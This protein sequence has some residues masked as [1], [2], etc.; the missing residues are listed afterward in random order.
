[1][2]M[3]FLIP[4]AP[5]QLNL[6]AAAQQHQMQRPGDAASYQHQAATGQLGGF[7]S[8]APAAATAPPTLPLPAGAANPFFN[9]PPLM[10]TGDASSSSLPRAPVAL[11]PQ[12][13][14]AG[15]S[16]LVAGGGAQLPGGG[17]AP[18]TLAIVNGVPVMLDLAKLVELMQMGASLSMV[19]PTADMVNNAAAAAAASAWSSMG[20]QAAATPPPAAKLADTRLA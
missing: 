7:M 3:P 17:V 19:Q 1:M 18:S 6:F 4:A 8:G 20:A 13:S 2:A 14:P 10:P 9:L 11:L 5:G 16:G 12:L 15:F